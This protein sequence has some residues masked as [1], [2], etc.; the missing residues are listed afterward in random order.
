MRQT[1]TQAALFPVQAPPRGY[2]LEVAMGA[3]LGAMRL[4]RGLTIRSLA[5]ATH[6]ADDQLLAYEAG[7]ER[8]LTGDL[9]TIVD[10][11][12]MKISEVFA[13]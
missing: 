8:V 7:R 13:G 12:D 6:I 4:R 2:G 1:Y 5:E 9:L 10:V 3:N 11:L